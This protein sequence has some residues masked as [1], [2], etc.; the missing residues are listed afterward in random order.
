M[1]G[2]T[3]GENLKG[4]FMRIELLQARLRFTLNTLPSKENDVLVSEVRAEGSD[5]LNTAERKQE[6]TGH[7]ILLLLLLHLL[8]PL[9]TTTSRTVS[10]NR[11]F[12]AAAV[13]INT[14]ACHHHSVSAPL[15][16]EGVPNKMASVCARHDG[17]LQ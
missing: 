5:W 1:T 10:L 15:H 7:T 8:L 6:L 17:P 16:W 13:N 2:T 4:P 11:L 9:A 12:T 14:L 3:T